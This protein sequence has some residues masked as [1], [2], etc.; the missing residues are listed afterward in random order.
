[1]DNKTSLGLA[2][3]KIVKN[4]LIDMGFNVKDAIDP[5]DSTTDLVLEGKKIEVK[6]QTPFIFKR[7][8]TIKD[9]HQLNKCLNADYLM[10][11]QAPCD[12]LEECAIYQV[13]KGFPYSKYVTKEGDKMV[14]IPMKDDKV[15]KLASYKKGTPEYKTLSK[16]RTNFKRV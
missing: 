10:F 8:F 3:E 13:D 12:A 2:G 16:Y 9:N 6:T 1:M 5:Y 11:V 7:S 4:Y 15:R 14:L